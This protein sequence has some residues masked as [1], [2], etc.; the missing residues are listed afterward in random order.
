MLETVHRRKT[1]E[2]LVERIQQYIAAEGLKPGDPLPTEHALAARLGVSRISLR[3]ATKTLGFLG[4]LEAKPG[5]GLTVGQINMNRLKES[6]GF[7][8]AL[9]TVP[10]DALID[11]RLIVEMGVMPHVARRMAQEPQI[12]DRLH[13]INAELRRTRDATR[14]VELDTAFH[15]L[16][17]QSS[18]LTP[19]A[20]FHDLLQVFFQRFREAVKKGGWQQGIRDHQ[21][22][23]DALRDR[24][25]T[26]A[27]K[28]LFR[29]ITEHRK[30]D[31]P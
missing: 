10:G 30:R 17:I 19:L 18:G 2:I 21:A 11:S 13:Q 25:P 29:H 15:Q 4:I 8:P 6:L 27:A 12:Y 31:Q 16:L 5:R 1:S 23:I 9:Q 3:E 22:V 24:R 28:I 7:H 26:K 14:F 20:A